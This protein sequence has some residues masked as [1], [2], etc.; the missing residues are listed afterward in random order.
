M[1]FLSARRH[2]MAKQDREKRERVHFCQSETRSQVP[3]V[4]NEFHRAATREEDLYARN[5]A[6]NVYSYTRRSKERRVNVQ[7]TIDRL[8]DRGTIVN[9]WGTGVSF[10]ILGNSP[11]YGKG[12]VCN[13]L[14]KGRSSETFDRS[15]I[16]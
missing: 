9:G 12:P 1:N 5:T 11:L 14:I 3:R 16:I 2:R 10:T 7:N 8:K 15:T 6:S 4:S 13:E